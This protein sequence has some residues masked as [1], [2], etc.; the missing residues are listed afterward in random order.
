MICFQIY[1]EL[2]YRAIGFLL[3]ARYEEVV[4]LW[5]VQLFKSL[6]SLTVVKNAK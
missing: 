4:P 5:P 1:Q 6:L 2:A 3:N